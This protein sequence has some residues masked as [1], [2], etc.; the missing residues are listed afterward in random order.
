MAPHSFK[1]FLF[2]LFSTL[3]IVPLSH[4]LQHPLDSLTPNEFIQVQAIVNQ[5][6]PTSNHNLTFQYVG[7]QEPNKQ[8]VISW[9]EKQTSSA[10][11]PPRQAFVIARINHKSH[12]IVVDFSIKRIVSDR[13][14]DGYGYPLLTFEE[15]TAANQLPLKYPPF[16]A[17][18]SK[19]GL[20]IDQVVCGSFTVGW[21]G[22]KKRN[23]RIVKV[24]CY[25]MDGTVNIYMRPIEAITV[26]VDLE[27][28]KILHFQDRLM[29]PVP[30]AKGT[31]YRESEQRAPFGPELKRITVVQ[32]D[33]PSFTIDGN[34]V[35]WAN[36][37]FHLSFDARVG[38][39]IS[40]A[41]IYDIEKGKFRRVMYRGFVSE[42]F[43]PYM[44]LTEEWYYRT[45]FDAGEYGYGLCAVPLQPLRDCPAN[46]VFLSGFVAGQ[47]GMPLE[48]PNVFCIF[49]RNA[50]DIMWRHTETMIPDVLVSEARPEVSLVVRMVST[51]GNYDYINDWEFKQMGSIKV[52]VGLT[53]LLEVRGSKYTHKDQINEE[54]YGTILAE[55]TL[56]A[57]HDHFLTYYLDLDV[58]GDSN[59]FVKSKLQTT[60]VTD[61]SSP[62]RSYWKVVSETAKTESDAKIK[63]GMEAA[64]L[65][66]VNPNKKTKM[67]NSVGYRLIP[68]SVSSPLLTED[69]YAQIRADFT[70][71]NVW[72]T[73]YNMSEKWAGGLYT[74]Q[75][76]GD[77]TLA[78]WTS[79]NRRIENKDIVM[80]YTLGFHHAPYQEDFPLMPTISS[81]FELR[82][83]NFFEYNPV[84]KVKDPL[85]PS[86]INQVKLIVDKSKLASLPNLTYHFVDLEEPD[87]NDVLKWLLD[88]DKQT[89]A[90][91]RQAKVVVRAGG[92]TWELVVDLTSGSI[93]SS[94]VY[95][96]HGFPPLTFND[97]LQASQLPFQYPKFKSSILKRGLNLSEV[98]CVPL[99]VGWYGEEVTR[100]ALRV[101]CYY[102]GGGA[103]NV[104]ARPIEGISIFVDVDLM[105]ITMYIDRFRVPVP[106]A[107]GTDFRSN[108]NPDSVIFNNVTENGFKLDGNNVNWENWNFHVG[109]DVRA[110]I[111]IS[112][113]SIFDAKTTKSRQVLYKGHVSETFVPYMDPENEWYFR[114]F[115]DIGEFGFGQS[116]SSLQP[117]IDCP[118]NA[119]YLDGHWA[120]ADGQP[121]KMQRAICIFERNSGDIAWRHAEIN[122]PGK[123][124]R[125][126]QPEKSLVVRMVATVGNYDYVLDWEFKKSGSIKVGVDLTGILLMKGTSYTNKDQI[127][128]NVYGTLVAEN[129]V[130]VNHDH[131]LTYYLD[132]DVDGNSNSFV[133]TKLQTER[134]KDFKASPRKSYWKIVRETAKTEADARIRL[135][136]EPA[137]LLIVN[138]NKKTK[139][140]NQVG[141]RLL[142][143]QP[144]TSL[145]ADD[146]YPQIRAA[147]T[148]YQ[149]WVTAYNKSER[150]A[151]GFYADRSHGD[152]G[153]AVW[154]QRNRMIENKDIVVWYTVGF[155]HIPYQEDFP[156]MPSFH[157]GFELRPANFFESNPLL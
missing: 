99:T 108:T 55:N 91:P 88:S 6:Y 10:T 128:A 73:P 148:K 116:A 35:R 113:A 137:E 120:G 119:V 72:V 103:V 77:D 114:T 139:L 104:Y 136:L 57:N 96:G 47:D 7:L 46:A 25:Y 75:S 101:T 141:Y 41:S 156:V 28:M 26:T 70:K 40:S 102:R 58:D 129:T 149:V 42:L 65:L 36:W 18:I 12:E 145:L 147:Y 17:S 38:P 33:G 94:H 100:R 138:P 66:M 11:P 29:V 90:L 130:A 132:L 37:D 122:V 5:S 13:I 135:G 20:K 62:R 3:S 68:G 121:L 69:D 1:I 24:M 109:F 92:D 155:H 14:Y 142:P 44:D 134:V 19:R 126:G 32:P 157:G 107:E 89:H 43:V 59:S 93:K 45:F 152:D 112:T 154:S 82:P 83:A 67:G 150:W 86:E 84:L 9:L 123:V 143:G 63:L 131:Y 151:G 85:T 133:K 118:G 50:G 125:S 117:L 60:R 127:T 49:E 31:D 105:E 144:T 153:L 74:D 39:I 98:S 54:V 27:E 95:T 48:Y 106:K 115:M 71:Y 4:Q 16:L 78:T 110:G 23:R 76:R 111:V 56:G 51:V 79:R 97:I 81:G 146:D 80:W 124:I 61:Q 22:E 53:G 21:Y 8:L 2:F 140:G 15:Q 52:T 64:D 30:K 87:K 34:R